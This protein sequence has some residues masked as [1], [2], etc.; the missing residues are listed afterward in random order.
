MFK[1]VLMFGCVAM[2]FAFCGC[3]SIEQGGGNAAPAIAA[4]AAVAAKVG[5]VHY[6]GKLREKGKITEEAYDLMVSIVESESDAVLEKELDTLVANGK[7]S[8]TQADNIRTAI[9][10]AQKIAEGVVEK[11]KEED[12]EDCTVTPA[13]PACEGDDCTVTP[14]EK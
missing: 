10:I 2:A 4:T 13:T 12:C 6:L 8:K 7:I 11:P 9:D 1:R 3:S 5:V 14:A